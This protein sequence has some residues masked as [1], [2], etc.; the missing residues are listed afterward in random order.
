M[1]FI[2]SIKHKNNLS[3]AHLAG[4]EMN[5]KGS[6]S[7]ASVWI[8]EVRLKTQLLL[9]LLG[10]WHLEKQNITLFVFKVQTKQHVTNNTVQ[11][12]QVTVQTKRVK[13]KLFAHVHTVLH[14]LYCLLHV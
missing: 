4:A 13:R 11:T 14:I 6:P 3:V 7:P 5:L 10:T 9:F 8:I 2:N 12:G 1:Q